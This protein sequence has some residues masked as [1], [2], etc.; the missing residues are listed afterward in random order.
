VKVLVTRI[1]VKSADIKEPHSLIGAICSYYE[2]LAHGLS[3]DEIEPG[4]RQVGELALLDGAVQDNGF[5]S[6]LSCHGWRPRAAED[7]VAAFEVIGASE[8]A[9]IVS[10]IAVRLNALSPDQMPDI[11]HGLPERRGGQSPELRALNE[12]LDDE[13]DRLCSSLTESVAIV[14]EHM[15]RRGVIKTASSDRQIDSEIE[16]I[17]ALSPTHQAK[18]RVIAERQ[19]R[20]RPYSQRRGEVI[21]ELGRLAGL[22]IYLDSYRLAENEFAWAARCW[23]LSQSADGR[24]D[25]GAEKLCY[26]EDG[27]KGVLAR[28]A[29]GTRLAVIKIEPGSTDLVERD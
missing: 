12:W 26:F 3:P 15:R 17:L 28:H 16:R 5:R 9:Q 4:C 20:L 29:D 27:D 10:T 6:Y 23:V 8:Q 24:P 2:N 14:A 22:S 13:I 18:V 11:T 25:F 7:I 19:E 1:L 21:A